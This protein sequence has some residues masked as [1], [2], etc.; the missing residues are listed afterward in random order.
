VTRGGFASLV[1]PSAAR[2][3]RAA[4]REFAFVKI[5]RRSPALTWVPVR[6]F[7]SLRDATVVRNPRAIDDSVSPFF[8]S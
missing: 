1:I 6:W 5:I 3:Q 2:V 8:T 4:R 7:Q